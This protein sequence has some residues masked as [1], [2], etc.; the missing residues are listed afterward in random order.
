MKS[1]IYVPEMRSGSCSFKPLSPLQKL[2]RAKLNIGFTPKVCHEYVE[3]AYAL[4]NK[5]ES[6]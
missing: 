3:H 6:T 2:T 5:G 4:A 1:G